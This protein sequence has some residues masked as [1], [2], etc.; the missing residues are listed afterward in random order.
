MSG[1]TL[2]LLT[3]AAVAAVAFQQRGPIQRYLSIERM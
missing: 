1:K 3:A 2:F